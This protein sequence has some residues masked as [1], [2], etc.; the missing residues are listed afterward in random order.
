MLLNIKRFGQWYVAI[1]FSTFV[2]PSN[3]LKLLIPQHFKKWVDFCFQV[4][5]RE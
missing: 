1:I 2:G 5:E 3:Y 4:D